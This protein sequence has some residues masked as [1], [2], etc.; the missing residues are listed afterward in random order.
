MGRAI[1]MESDI[2]SLKIRVSKLE[3]ILEELSKPA[4]KTKKKKAKLE[5]DDNDLPDNVK[6][7][8]KD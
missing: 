6:A 2:D 1:D 3:N 4:P 8:K 5:F 7:V